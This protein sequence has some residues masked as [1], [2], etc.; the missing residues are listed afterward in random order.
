[1]FHLQAHDL[2]FLIPMALVGLLAMGAIPVA[3]KALR[4]SLLRR[5][6]HRRLVRCAGSRGVAAADL[7]KTRSRAPL[8]ER[9]R[10]AMSPPCSPP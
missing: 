3:A 9:R 10:G 4:I 8:R 7:A 2:V 5:R 6:D 1:M